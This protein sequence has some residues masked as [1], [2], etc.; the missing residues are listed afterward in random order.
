[1]PTSPLSRL[2]LAG[3]TLT[4]LAPTL[5]GCELSSSVPREMMPPVTQTG[6]NKAG[7]L[8][9][10]ATWLPLAGVLFGSPAYRVRVN[11]TPQ[12][13][14]GFEFSL[15]LTRQAPEGSE[16]YYPKPDSNIRF[17]LPSVLAPGS[18]ALNESV[19]APFPSEQGRHG[20]LTDYTTSPVFHY[21]TGSGPAS[22]QLVITRF[23]TVARVV[24]GTFEFTGQR[25]AE[26]IKVTQGRFD[27]IY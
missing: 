9:N 26:L 25:G 22:G 14:R 6:A 11:R 3:L 4:L 27:V 2:L 5:S 7:A 16:K 19:T 12:S 17:F 18:F 1:M 21:P 23:D 24:A 8:V 15:S 20:V 10:G 13:G